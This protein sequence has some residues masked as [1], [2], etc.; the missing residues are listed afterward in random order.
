MNKDNLI[1]D[2]EPYLLY[3]QLIEKSPRGR[4]ITTK[5]VDYL[6]K[7]NLNIYT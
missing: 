3:P 5:G 6:I 2:I 7:N 4:R 1:N